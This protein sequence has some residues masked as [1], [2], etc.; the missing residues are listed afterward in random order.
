MWGINGK[1][2]IFLG[3]ELLMAMLIPFHVATLS[4]TYEKDLEESGLV[5]NL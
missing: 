4:S 1:E 5:G 3:R 2:I